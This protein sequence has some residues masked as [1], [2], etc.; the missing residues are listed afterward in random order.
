MKKKSRTKTVFNKGDIVR[1]FIGMALEK[2]WDS[3]WR[4]RI[5][6]QNQHVPVPPK[7]PYA[8]SSCGEIWFRDRELWM[9]KEPGDCVIAKWVK[10]NLLWVNPVIEHFTQMAGRELLR[11]SKWSYGYRAR[12]HGGTISAENQSDAEGVTVMTP[13]IPNA[14]SH[15]FNLNWLV[16]K[17]MDPTILRGRDS[18]ASRYI[19]Y[20]QQ[21]LADLKSYAQRFNL[22]VPRQDE[23]ATYMDKCKTKAVLGKITT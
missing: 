23:L 11:E 18:S 9:G 13:R 20:G 2:G 16:D 1:S 8:R 5:D 21:K 7:I 14:A 10:G 4:E 15:K 19:R 3:R 12:A 22:D 17:V 6:A